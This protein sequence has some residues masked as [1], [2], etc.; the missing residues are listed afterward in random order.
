[1]W[2]T[3]RIIPKPKLLLG[4]ES[5][6][7]W[8]GEKNG[9]TETLRCNTKKA[10]FRL[11]TWHLNVTEPVA[12][13][14]DTEPYKPISI[15]DNVFLIAYLALVMSSINHSDN[16]V[17]SLNHI[18]KSVINWQTTPI[19]DLIVIVMEIAFNQFKDLKRVLVFLGQ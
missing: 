16:L 19:Q 13:I 12:D 2:K 17:K 11:G 7:V 15:P 5:S 9:R 1:M 14:S 18:F 8:S 3:K 6:P 10:C 4:L